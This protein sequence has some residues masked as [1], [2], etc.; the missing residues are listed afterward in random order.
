MLFLQGR[1]Q[2]SL[3]P[4]HF[5]S[6]SVKAEQNPVLVFQ[7]GAHGEDAVTPYNRRSVAVAGEFSFPDD[8]AVGAPVDWRLGFQAGTVAARS[9]PA[10]PILGR[11]QMQRS[12][13]TEHAVH[14][15]AKEASRHGAAPVQRAR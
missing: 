6:P 14:A 11:G 3:V 15:T 13:Q 5:A 4:E 1:L 9:A 7:A 10:R 12:D 8:V 2:H